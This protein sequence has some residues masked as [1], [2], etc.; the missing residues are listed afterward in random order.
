MFRM[1]G[2]GLPSDP[3]GGVCASS[4]SSLRDPPRL[5][6]E[7]W[8]RA[9]SGAIHTRDALR[10]NGGILHPRRRGSV[11]RLRYDS[12]SFFLLR[13]YLYRAILA[14]ETRATLNFS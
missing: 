11:G 12:T 5:S 10:A 4:T 6:P 1:T 13:K 2:S 9:R 8:K 14:L 3:S 7:T